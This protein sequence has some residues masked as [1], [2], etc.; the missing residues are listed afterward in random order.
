MWV[1][2]SGGDLDGSGDRVGSPGIQN[3]AGCVVERAGSAS[4]RLSPSAYRVRRL[5]V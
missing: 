1:R 3:G 4:R 2:D 5:P